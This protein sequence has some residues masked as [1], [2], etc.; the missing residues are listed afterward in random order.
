M[1]ISSSYHDYRHFQE[2]TKPHQKVTEI[3]NQYTLNLHSNAYQ[4]CLNK[5]GKEFKGL[6]K[7]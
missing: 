2:R 7:K 5:T 4:L 3:I 1:E 6:Q